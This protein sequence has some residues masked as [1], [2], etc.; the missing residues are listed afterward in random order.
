MTSC[1]RSTMQRAAALVALA[2]LVAA[3][4]CSITR[5][6][7]VKD[8]FLLEPALPAAVAKPQA[9]SLRVGSVNVAAPFRARGFVIR[10]SELRFEADFYH[11]FFVPP[12]VMI[13]DSTA[14]ALSSATMVSS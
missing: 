5:P 11:E 10:E 3:T 7:P 14:R 12:G 13:A 9:G 2:A 6:A 1:Q 4:G 8:S